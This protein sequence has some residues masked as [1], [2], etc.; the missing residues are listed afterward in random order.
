MVQNK[1]AKEMWIYCGV[2][3]LLF[4]LFIPVLTREV[5]ERKNEAV[6]KAAEETNGDVYTLDGTALDRAAPDA[7]GDKTTVDGATTDQTAPGE[8]TSDQAAKDEAV[9]N[10]KGK[11]EN[12]SPETAVEAAVALPEINIADMIWPLKGEVIR[13]VGLSY[14]QTFS[15][16]RYHNGIDIKA[17]RGAEVVMPL[18]GKVI[19]KETTREEGIVLT[20]EHGQQNGVVWSS[21]F[22]H[23]SETSLKEGDYLE[24]GAPVGSV[25]QP[26]Y[27]EIMEGPHLHYSLYQNGQV[28]NPLDYLP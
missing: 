13:E 21:V 7:D 23:L 12:A 4:A 19:K 14:A 28:V 3:L 6:E 18:P 22:A 10:D 24:I 27:N 17:D 9:A 25:D 1:S 20:V 26:G 11:E 8:A 16:Y 15:D 2:V 5:K